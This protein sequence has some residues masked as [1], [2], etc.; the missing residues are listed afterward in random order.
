MFRINFGNHL[1]FF[2]V[3]SREI[4]N[5]NIRNEIALRNKC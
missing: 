3:F 2:N 1:L 4:L 5:G